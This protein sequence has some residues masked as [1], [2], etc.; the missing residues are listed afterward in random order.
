MLLTTL[1]VLLCLGAATIGGVFFAFSTF[2]MRALGERPAAEGIAA[3]QRINVVVLNPLFLGVF[4][5]SAGLS[6][7]VI[8]MAGLPW[9]GSRSAWLMTA[10]LL[11]GLGTFVVT[12]VFNVPRN[13]RLAQLAATTPEGATYWLRYQ[14]EWTWW[15]HV[16]TAAAL[17]AAACCLAALLARG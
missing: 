9:A 4:V 3:M 12:M 1:A 16:R 7:A 5:G 11:Y 2:V 8:V 17:L 13:D 15:N 10:G 14:R 6:V